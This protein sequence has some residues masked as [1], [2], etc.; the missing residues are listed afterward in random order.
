MADNDLALGRMIEALSKTPFWRTSV[1]FVLE[2]DA[3]NGADH[4]DSHRSPVLVISPYSK[5]GV[6]HRFANTTDVIATMEEILG[7]GSLGPYDYFGRPLRDAFGTTPDLKPYVAITPSVDLK[8]RNP[9]ASLGARESSRLDLSDA[10]RADEAL[11]NHIL[12]LAIKGPNVPEPAPR[13]AS[14][15]DLAIGR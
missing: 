10:D 7:L 14:T 1:V 5:G 6:I 4:V 8:E 13:R 11:F 2:D 15:L 3:Q 9:A 12:W